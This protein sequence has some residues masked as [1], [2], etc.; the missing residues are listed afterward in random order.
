K[1]TYLNVYL[2]ENAVLELGNTAGSSPEELRR[3][4]FFM[5]IYGAPTSKVILHN[6]VVVNGSINV[7]SLEVKND[8]TV[9][10]MTSN[11]GQVAKQK[12][13]EMWV[14]SNYSD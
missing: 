12:I 13:D 3:L 1:I 4:N 6:N 9:N 10:Y 5:S 14:L 8:A 2:G 7:G 11:G